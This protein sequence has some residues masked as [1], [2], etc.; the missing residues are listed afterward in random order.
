MTP[1]EEK[2][3]RPSAGE[4]PTFPV[5]SGRRLSDSLLWRLQRES[6]LRRGEQAWLVDQVPFYITSN[7]YIAGAY[8]RVLVG[9]LR[10]QLAAG[11]AAPD[12]PFHVL[13]LAS[14]PGQFAFLFL[15]KLLALVREVPALAGLRLRYVMSDLAPANVEAWRGRSSLRPF[16]DAGLLDFAVFDLERDRRLEL[17]QSGET[18]DAGA[19]RNPLTVI[20]NY[21][22]DTT[23]QD[24]FWIHEGAL[25]EGRA[26]LLSS[27]ESD[28]LADPQ[29][30]E[31]LSVRYERRPAPGACYDDEALNRV[32]A[33]Y[34]SRLGDTSLLFPIGALRGIRNLATLAGGRLLLVSGDKGYSHE[35]ELLAHGD[36]QLTLHGGQ[37]FSMMVNYHAIGLYVRELGGAVL[38]GATH[39]KRLKVSA[40]VLGGSGGELPETAAAFRQAIDGFSPADYFVLA[41]GVRKALPA[42]PLEMILSLLKLGGFD[43]QLVFRFAAPLAEQARSAPES[44]RLELL[45]AL[46]KCWEHFYPM[47]LDLPFELGRIYAALERPTDALRF[48]LESLRLYKEHPATL[49]NAGLCLCRLQRPREALTLMERALALKADYAPAREWRVKIQEELAG[50]A[51]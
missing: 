45:R 38:H 42:A 34:A 32:L 14:G 29:A 2:E 49:F 44:Q 26:T 48:Y 19:L 3:T 15:K 51:S 30:L 12:A 16:V 21:A 47:D 33:G 28:E 17:L 37:C 1:S 23:A 11:A 35:S 4:Q 18:L 50:S 22:F 24:V 31:R 8:A 6:Y 5:E 43:P 41:S 7:T 25:Q 46:E 13:E 36:P 10:D 20:A 27:R 9:F 40:F 39:D